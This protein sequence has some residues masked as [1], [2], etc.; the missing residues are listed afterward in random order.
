MLYYLLL[1]SNPSASIITQIS[2]ISTLI[3]VSIVFFVFLLLVVRKFFQL[4]AENK[5]ISGPTYMDS[6]EDKK[7]YKD[8]KD[9]YLYG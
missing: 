7:V 5:R 3:V 8:F 9:G 6:I 2:V 1:L 4:K